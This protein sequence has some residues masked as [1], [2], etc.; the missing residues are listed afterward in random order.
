MYSQK[1]KG[2]KT[3]YLYYTISNSLK[4]EEISLQHYL[5]DAYEMIH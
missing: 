3:S 2:I 1:M 4:K 5:A